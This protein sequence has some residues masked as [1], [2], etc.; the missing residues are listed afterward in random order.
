MDNKPKT[1][2]QFLLQYAG[3]TFQFLVIIGIGVYAGYYIDRWIK[4]GFPL[5]LWLLP[6]IFII[7]TIVKV[8]KDT[9]KK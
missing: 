1:N 3:L 7:G 8:I 9:S 6:L 4:I 5:F 2:K